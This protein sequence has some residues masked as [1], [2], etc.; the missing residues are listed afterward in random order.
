[1]KESLARARRGWRVIAVCG[2]LAAL[3][4]GAQQ[5]SLVRAASTFA[6]AGDQLVIKVWP[7]QAFGPPVTV[8]VDPRGAIVLPQVG[9]VS[10]NRIPIL[11]I[12]D[13]LKTRLA[14]YIRDPEVDVTVLRRVTVNGAVMR[15]DIYYMD[16]SASL[17]DAIARAG[18]ITEV[19]NRNRVSVIR[20]GVSRRVANW[21]T[22]T[23]DES[24]LR[25]GDQV[26]VGRRSFFAINIIPIV[27][28]GLATASFLI[29][30]KK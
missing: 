3:P 17:R 21:E 24:T 27:S 1:M 12:R 20:D 25:S 13:T 26:L 16:V 5:G 4:A 8:S 23:S 10:V 14:R 11:E 2:V 6:Q 28:L 15:P 29:S 18:G 30:L 7:Q 19:G 9:L 22:D